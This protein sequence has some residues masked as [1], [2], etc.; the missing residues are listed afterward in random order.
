M[1]HLRDVKIN[2]DTKVIR[3]G[4]VVNSQSR[5]VSNGHIPSDDSVNEVVRCC[6]FLEGPIPICA[7]FWCFIRDNTQ[8]Y[9]IS[10]DLEDPDEL[11]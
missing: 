7:G 11:F 1:C 9:S 3:L 6:E 4:G 8:H 2:D 5:G 10:L